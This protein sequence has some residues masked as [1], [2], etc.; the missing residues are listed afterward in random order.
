[1]KWSWKIATLAGV[2][3]YLHVTFLVLVAWIALGYWQT[4]GNLGAVVTGV[5]FILSLFF[6]VLL[7]ELGHA[8]TARRYGIRTRAITLLPIGGIASIEKTPENPREEM[9]IALAGP[10]V[11]FGIAAL[12]WVLLSASGRPFLPLDQLN[13]QPGTFWQ[14]L[15]L[16]NL[17]LGAFNLLPAF[18][19]DGGR[20]LRAALALR[21]G[22][23]K[24]TRIAAGVAQGAA[25][26]LAVIGLYHNLFLVLIA[27][28]IWFGATAESSMATV[29]SMLAGVRA[30][31]AMVTEFHTL[32]SVDSL[33]HA[34]ELTLSGTQ[35]DFPVTRDGELVGVLRQSDLVRGL[36]DHGKLCRVDQVMQ[37]GVRQVEPD[38][39][40][41]GLLEN[42][43]AGDAALL[44]VMDRGQLAGIID[45]ENIL[46]LLRIEKALSEHDRAAA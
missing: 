4:E 43:Q 33:G 46:E 25:V 45:V 30:R 11:S 37:N 23:V 27:I 24:A 8:L 44:A 38:D 22:P 39:P 36:H 21:L 10:A 31:N 9:I 41:E 19:M 13:L 42:L 7:H 14:R 12:L 18:P 2:D 32:Q 34:A 35:K 3:V 5:G 29:T 6:C 15:M 20:V 26:L 17:L 1:M 16:V 40:L 28:F